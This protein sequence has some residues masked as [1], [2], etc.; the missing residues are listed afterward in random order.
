MEKLNNQLS[1]S[2][3]GSLLMGAGLAK[4]DN[5]EIG[6]TLIGIGAILKIIVALLQKNNIPVESQG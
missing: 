6:L 2:T 1:I 5:I 3:A 4:L